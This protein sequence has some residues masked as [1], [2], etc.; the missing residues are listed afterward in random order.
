MTFS[1]YNYD[2][3]PDV[4][5][6]L[7]GNINNNEDFTEFT[8]KWIEL[9]ENKKD[10]N[11]IFNT[12]NIGFIHP[13]YCLFVAL[14]IKTIKKRKIQYLKY[15]TINVYNKYIYKLLKIVFYI[16]KPVAPV[17]INFLDF[18]KNII[19]SKSINP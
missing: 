15:S 1:Y 11:F 14:F 10:F 9:Y 17:V 5:V 19:N 6:E 8:S 18:E 4:Y 12:K 3:F 2:N 16:E 13:K 7:S